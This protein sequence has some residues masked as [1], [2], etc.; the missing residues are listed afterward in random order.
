MANLNSLQGNLSIIAAFL[1][2]NG[3]VGEFSSSRLLFLPK[4]VDMNLLLSIHA[5]CLQAAVS[6]LKQEYK[7]GETNLQQGL[8]M[9]IKV[10][11]KTL[12]TNKLTPEKGFCHLSHTCNFISLS[13]LNNL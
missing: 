5:F 11:S 3:V 12:D 10:L 4:A 8:E 2:Y 9:A 7:D 6:M 1:M 13:L